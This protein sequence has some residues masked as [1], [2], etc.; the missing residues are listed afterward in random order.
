MPAALPRDLALDLNL[1][2]EARAT[3][4]LVGI[5]LAILVLSAVIAFN[6]HPIFRFFRRA[7]CLARRDPNQ[8][9]TKGKGSENQPPTS[10]SH[11]DMPISDSPREDRPSFV[12]RMPNF[13][14]PIRKHSSTPRYSSVNLYRGV[15]GL[16]TPPPA[17]LAPSYQPPMSPPDA[18]S[19]AGVTPHI[20]GWMA[21]ADAVVGAHPHARPLHTRVAT[22]AEI[23]MISGHVHIPWAYKVDGRPAP[24][25]VKV[26]VPD[27][28][29]PVLPAQ[30][31]MLRDVGNVRGAGRD[32]VAGDAESEG[33]A[34][35][36]RRPTKTKSTHRTRGK[37]NVPVTSLPPSFT[38][39]RF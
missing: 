16:H 12:H 34:Q 33:G 30:P 35:V 28:V 39:G 3:L 31:G 10:S 21:V 14:S 22:K 29:Y 2:S 24:V 25:A 37:E 7:L 32:A 38:R 19:G 36:G 23:E 4:I 6:R 8:A 20:A 15:R 13:F 17:R 26:Q 18:Y 11:D 9:D 5:L 1:E 27:V